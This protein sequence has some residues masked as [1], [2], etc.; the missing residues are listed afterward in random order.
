M[1]KVGPD[2]TQ[3]ELN[4]NQFSVFI[5]DD[6]EITQRILKSFYLKEGYKVTLFSEPLAA[7]RI[8]EKPVSA[9]QRACD[10]IICDLK[11][12][13]LDGLEFIEKLNEFDN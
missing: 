9:S 10:L 7:L 8:L 11:M 1:S 3:C 5:I 2:V 4:N 6:D 12:P 13:S